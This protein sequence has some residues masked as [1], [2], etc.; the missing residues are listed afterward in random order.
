MQKLCEPL[1]LFKEARPKRIARAITHQSAARDD[2]GERVASRDRIESG[3]PNHL[4]R[5]LLKNGRT[6]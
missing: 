1:Y 5:R 3:K 4:L 2:P 6:T